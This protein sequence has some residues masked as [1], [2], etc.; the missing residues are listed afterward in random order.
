MRAHSHTLTLIPTGH[1]RGSNSVQIY[2]A[3]M[4][5]ILQEEI[6]HYTMPFID[7]LLVKSGMTRYQDKDGSY[8]TILE[9]PG[10]HRFIWEHLIIVNWVLQHVQNVGATVSA[11]KFML[12]APDVV[13][14]GHKCTFEGRI[15]HEAKVQK[16]QDWPECVS[17]AH[18]RGFLGTCGV[19]GIFIRNFAV[20]ARP[21]VN[22][23]QKGVPFEWGE[24]QQKEMQCLKDEIIQSPVLHRLDYASRQE[25]ILAVDTSMIAVGYIL[26]QEDDDRKHYPNCFG[27]F[28]LMEVKSCYSQAK[29]E[30]YG[31]FRALR[32]VR[33]FI[34]G[35][36]NLTVKM[37]EKYVEGMI[38][39]P[40]LQPNVTINR[41]IAGILLF[42]FKLVHISADKHIGPDG[43]S[44]QPPA[45]EDPPEENVIENWLDNAYSFAVVLLNKRLHPD[46][47][48]KNFLYTHIALPNYYGGAGE[49]PEVEL[50]YSMVFVLAESTSQNPELKD[51]ALPHSQKAKVCEAR[52][53]LIH[54][55]LET[56]ECL[57]GMLDKDYQSFINLATHCFIL[58]GS[59][60]G[61]EP[62]G[63]HQL[64]VPESRRFRWIKEAHDNL[65][66]KGV[67][68]VRTRLL[69]RFWW[70]MLVE[71]VKWYI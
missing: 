11:K 55:F 41:W 3:D 62:H 61:R 17:V 68:T 8:K 60:W 65:G 10:I 32:V 14:V 53:Q 58:N 9:N 31:L 35:I 33:I 63:K 27:S 28:S 15:P 6:P 51:S 52:M 43:L 30:L 45:A 48:S 25:V 37:N 26:S 7:D 4:S 69:W 70:P 16:I 40:D 23:T 67:F 39:N 29:L 64:V 13:I 24:S 1:T 56:Q 20:I 22:L 19:L 49:R 42:H 2:Q 5:F 47:Y 57:D 71:D 54:H 38:N 36:A 12:A 44:R 34:F 18:I 46:L 66:H 59:L 21:L 50:V